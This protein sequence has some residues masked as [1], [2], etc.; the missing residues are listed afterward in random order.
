MKFDKISI[1]ILAI[2]SIIL[3]AIIFLI[4]IY[5]QNSASSSPECIPPESLVNLN[6]NVCFDAETKNIILMLSR[7]SDSYKISKLDISFVDGTSRKF[8]IEDLPN[9]KEIRQYNFFSSKNPERVKLLLSLSS[10]ENTCNN[11]K[12][13][14]VKEC[15]G[16]INAS[17]FVEE[18][19]QVNIIPNK[20]S[21]IISQN[22]AK[23]RTFLLNC[24]S[25]WHCN[26]WE[27]CIEGKQQRICT[28]STNCLIPS[29]IPDFTQDCNCKENW[30]CTWSNCQNGFTTPSCK[31][32]NDCGFD[33]SKPETLQCLSESACSPSV[34]C[35]SWSNCI[36]ELGISQLIDIQQIKGF[37]SRLC[38]DK[39]N[40]ISPTYERKECSITSNIYT[41]EIEWGNEKYLE[42][43]EKSTDK[44]ISRVKYSK[45]SGL[46]LGFYFE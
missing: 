26:D 30:Q 16:A 34:E 18:N 11:Q 1:I 23:N 12:T 5:L 19:G 37:K 38:K 17:S 36:I 10:I 35:E 43:Y 7:G 41:K 9:Y 4:I 32:L 44:L 3:I 42:V 25:N 2:L 27:E 14:L 24:Q 13:Y 6:S 21:D 39:N 40:C 31:D 46:S 29:D 20:P 33:D 8:S 15:S 28:D 45:Q 22:L